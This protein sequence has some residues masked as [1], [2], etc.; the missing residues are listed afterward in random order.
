[1][2]DAAIDEWQNARTLNP[3]IPVLHRNLGRTLLMVKH[4][5]PVP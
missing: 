5:D 2:T 3:N 1:M 4:D